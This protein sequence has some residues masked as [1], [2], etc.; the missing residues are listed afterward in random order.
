MRVIGE[1]FCTL[2]VFIVAQSL[3]D[4]DSLNGLKFK[5]LLWHAREGARSV[6][7]H[8]PNGPAAVSPLW[9]I[10]SWKD[11]ALASAASFPPRKTVSKITPK[12]KAEKSSKGK[13]SS[14]LFRGSVFAL[15]RLSPPEGSVDYNTK[16][17][18]TCITS[19][20]GQLLS[21]ELVEALRA[22]KASKDNQLRN[23]YVVCWGGYTPVHMMVH[24]LLSRIEKEK[25]CNVVPVTPIWLY[26]CSVDRKLIKP[27]GHP[28]LFQPQTWSIHRL[29]ELKKRKS[30]EDSMK[31]SVTGFVGSERTGIIQALRVLGVHYTENLRNTNTHLICKE[32][33]GP[34][35]E[36]ATKWGL[37]VVSIEWMYHIMEYGYGGKDGG[38]S[39]GG[40]EERF[41]FLLAAEDACREKS[42]ELMANESAPIL[43]QTGS[44]GG[45]TLN[46][47]FESQRSQDKVATEK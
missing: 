29:P 43:N 13:P 22:D 23:C 7:L 19:H 16:E 46:A 4:V 20:G 30:E 18:E 34:K 42:Q 14:S 21:S 10:T 8:H 40:C 17:L 35:Y 3:N 12:T 24:P 44:N 37:H 25:L 36:K 27:M 26:S 2:Y 9:I 31:I 47:E 32:S 28:L 5:Q 6:S 15:L 33:K 39:D 38:D 45:V 41:S 11:D 1:F